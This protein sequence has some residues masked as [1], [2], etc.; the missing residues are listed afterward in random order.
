MDSMFKH[1]QQRNN[2]QYRTNNSTYVFFNIS[3]RF[4][5]LDHN[6][7]ELTYILSIILRGILCW[8]GLIQKTQF[9]LKIL[10]LKSL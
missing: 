1:K 5:L 7:W 8:F 9:K 3:L 6:N 4:S 2:K 10:N